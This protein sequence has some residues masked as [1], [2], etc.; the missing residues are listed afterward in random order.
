MSEASQAVFCAEHP[1]VET[2]LR[3]GRCG[4][5]ICPRCLIQT[6]VGARC[7]SCARVRRLPVYDVPP[8]FL[9]RGVAAGLAAA[10]LGGIVVHLVPGFGL[11]LLLMIGGVYGYLVAT[12]VARATN[13]KRGATLGWVTVGAIVLGFWLSRVALVYVRSEGLPETVRVTRALAA[14]LGLD[15][16]TLAFLFVAALVAYNRLR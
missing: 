2:Y 13:E 3:C 4:Q 8:R 10:T 1:S 12:A 16:A 6:P 7:R 15:L 14:A 5:P 11:F 9:L